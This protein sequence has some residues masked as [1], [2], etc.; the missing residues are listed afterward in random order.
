MTDLIKGQVQE[1]VPGNIVLSVP[2]TLRLLAIQ[3]WM[4][5]QMDEARPD[6]TAD[7]VRSI[8]VQ[9]GGFYPIDD[10]WSIEP[11]LH[12]PA[13]LRIHITR[14]AY[15]IADKAKQVNCIRPVEHGI[16]FIIERTSADEPSLPGFV[17]A[18]L[19]LL[20]ALSTGHPQSLV[21]SALSN[22]APLAKSMGLLLRNYKKG[23]LASIARLSCLFR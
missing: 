23:P 5:G 2:A 6:F 1:H 15:E 22:I 10:I 12:S 4:T 17:R 3:Q 18:V 14:L 8:P 16:G 20:R 7:V 9:T 11:T 13:R 21:A 19:S